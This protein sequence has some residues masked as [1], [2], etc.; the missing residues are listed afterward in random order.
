MDKESY[1]EIDVKVLL[2]R[3]REIYGDA[4]FKEKYESVKAGPE[5]VER[6][7]EFYDWCY[8]RNIMPL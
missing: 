3:V 4:V 7:E 1:G 5:Y 8:G 6:M 2:I